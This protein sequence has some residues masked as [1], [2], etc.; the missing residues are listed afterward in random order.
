MYPCVI[1]NQ[2]KQTFLNSLLS[3]TPHTHTQKC[4]FKTTNNNKLVKQQHGKNKFKI[5]FIIGKTMYDQMIYTLNYDTQNC[6]FFR[7]YTFVEKFDH[8]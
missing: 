8:Y 1:L 4:L 6:P 5:N 2:S 7:F 3:P